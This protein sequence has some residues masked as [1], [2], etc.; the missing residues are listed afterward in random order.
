MTVPVATQD[1]Q[2]AVAA[3]AQ[4]G[5]AAAL[6]TADAKDGGGGEFKPFGED[7]FT[8]LDLIDII[9]P[10]Q[11]IPFVSNLYRE[12]SGDIIDPVSRV[13]GGALFGGPIGA[14]A[15]AVNM[16]VN[17]TTGEDIGG[18]ILA[19]FKD[20]GESTDGIELAAGPS[21]GDAAADEPY[22][23]AT[24][25]ER[26]ILRVEAGLGPVPVR[27]DDGAAKPVAA[28]LK[29]E[30]QVLEWAQRE[31]ARARA[32]AN[33]RTYQTAAATPVVPAPVVPAEAGALAVEGGW[34]SEVMLS[35][36]ESYRKAGAEG[37]P[38]PGRTINVVN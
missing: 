8:F 27:A 28:A 12:I 24:Q 13:L 25:A 34:F 31:T 37:V 21:P 29:D 16:V 11:H 4:S 38:P 33:G 26:D 15:A 2:V 18:H 20:G 7:G 32:L 9:N 1:P 30:I 17:E 19:M 3:P 23:A 36:L 35:A 5:G 10:L 6:R 14:A 22:A